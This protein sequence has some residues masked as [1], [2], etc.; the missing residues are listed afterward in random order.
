[1]VTGNGYENAPPVS[2]DVPA[3]WRDA[4]EAAKASTFLKNA[5]GEEMHRVF[6]AIKQSEYLRVARTVSEL[7]YQLYMHEV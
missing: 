6:T 4:I 5:L 1:M 2:A 7:D 3:D